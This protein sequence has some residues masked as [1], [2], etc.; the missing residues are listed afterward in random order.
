MNRII[1]ALGVDDNRDNRREWANT[2]PP[3]F[4]I[5]L[6]IITIYEHGSMKHHMDIGKINTMFTDICFVL[7]VIP[8]ELH[9]DRRT[10][11]F[12]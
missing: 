7:L 6:M 12:R 8:L 9:T 10:L 3:L 5:L 1:S 11:M 2:D 4:T